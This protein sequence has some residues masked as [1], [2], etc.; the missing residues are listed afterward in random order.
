MKT[1][2]SSSP[3]SLRLKRYACRKGQT[4]TEYALITAVIS[5]VG[6]AAFNLLGSKII[7]IMS[8]VAGVLDTAQ[9]SH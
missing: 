1:P 3:L 6:L 7:L 4:L 5:V 8:A 9:S 2:V